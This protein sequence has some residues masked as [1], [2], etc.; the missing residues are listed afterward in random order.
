M[1]KTSKKLVVSD[2]KQLLKE[3]IKLKIY[4]KTVLPYEA[5]AIGRVFCSGR[6]SYKTLKRAIAD[7]RRELNTDYLNFRFAVLYFPTAVPDFSSFAFPMGTKLWL[8][9]MDSMT[10]D[11]RFLHLLAYYNK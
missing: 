5:S 2:F 6:S 1:C 9:S 10:D 11:G 4:S 8:I 7:S 3:L